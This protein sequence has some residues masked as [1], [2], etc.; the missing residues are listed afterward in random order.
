[1]ALAL[2]VSFYP[3]AQTFPTCPIRDIFLSKSQGKDGTDNL[4]KTTLK[5]S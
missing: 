4:I 1:M 5:E 3:N 2:F